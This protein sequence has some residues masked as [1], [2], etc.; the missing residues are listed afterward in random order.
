MIKLRAGRGE[1]HVQVQVQ[2]LSVPYLHLWLF[3]I[4]ASGAEYLVH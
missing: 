3:G 1:V 2:V 4:F